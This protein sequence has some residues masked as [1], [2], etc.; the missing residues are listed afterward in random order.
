MVFEDLRF[1][2]SQQHYSVFVKIPGRTGSKLRRCDILHKYT[3]TLTA[4]WSRGAANERRVKDS[5]SSQSR[6]LIAI[7][8]PACR[9]FDLRPVRDG[10]MALEPT[11]Q[12]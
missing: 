6:S 5:S 11:C 9:S 1:P 4:D 10:L 2:G 3:S 8:G 12:R 7:S